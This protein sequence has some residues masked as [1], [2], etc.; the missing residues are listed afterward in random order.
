MRRCLWLHLLD[1]DDDANDEALSNLRLFRARISLKERHYLTSNILV[2]PNASPWI[3]LYG[4]IDRSAFIT[5]VSL[6][7]DAFHN[8][9]HEFSKHFTWKARTFK[10][11]RPP[12]LPHRHQALALVLHYYTAACEHKTMCEMFGVPPST[13]AT[14]L[15]K[16]EVALGLAL[17]SM[18]HA[19]VHYPSKT[20]MEWARQVAEREPLVHGVWGF[21]DGKNYRVKSP[22]SADLQ[23]AM[24]NG[25]LHSVFVTGTLLFGADGTIVWCR[26]NFV[27]SWNDGDTSINLQMKLLDGKRTA[28]G[29][30]VVA[31]AAFPVRGE[32]LG[33]IRTPLKDGDLDRA[34]PICREGLLMMSNAITSLR[35]AAEWGMGAVEKVYRQLLLPLPF[36]PTLRRLRLNNM[37]RLYNYRVRCTGISQ[38][39]STL[40]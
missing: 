14:T 39:R 13:F 33:K 4:K 10:S 20:Q 37:F 24:F 5:T 21:L 22:S 16:A 34:S 27:G 28:A 1:D 18:D 32:L 8:L 26:H 35:Q 7:L 38:I 31:D 40:F 3:V 25:W 9:L 2:P 29:H 6:P 15:R 23:N 17:E 12:K 30:G 11:G 19:R 36:D